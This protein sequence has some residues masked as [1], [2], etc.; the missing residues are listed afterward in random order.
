MYAGIHATRS[1]SITLY[2]HS[3][4]CFNILNYNAKHSTLSI[5]IDAKLS[6]SSTTKGS[7]KRIL[8]LYRDMRTNPI[9][10]CRVY[11]DPDNM[12]NW[13]ILL[14]DLPGV[15]SGGIWLLTVDF[16]SDFPFT[17]PVIRFVTPIYHC[18]ISRDGLICMDELK[19]S[20]SPANTMASIVRSIRELLITPNI[21]NPLDTFKASSYRDYI[22]QGIPAYVNDATAFTK[23]NAG[24][25]LA[26]M[27]ELYNLV[28]PED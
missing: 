2:Q 24:D 16:K 23:A 25:S 22:V 7:T 6:T 9:E 10:G 28:D 19:D 3:L 4:T 15:Y 17:A 5:Q 11:M 14:S 27:C 12:H 18:N 20:W 8:R 13:K 1:N 21:D 26:A